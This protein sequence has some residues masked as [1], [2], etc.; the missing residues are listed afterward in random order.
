MSPPTDYEFPPWFWDA[1]T[2]DQQRAIWM[3]QERCRRQAQRQ[4]T[5][6][7][8]AAQSR[9]ERIERRIESRPHTV[10]LSEYR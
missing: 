2:S 1:D 7:L 3:T 9:A 10:D 5:P 8:D 6:Y 4:T